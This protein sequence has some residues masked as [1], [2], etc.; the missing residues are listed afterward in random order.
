MIRNGQVYCDYKNCHL[1]IYK[2][3]RSVRVLRPEGNR[4]DPSDFAHFHDRDNTD[5][6][7][8][9]IRDA[10]RLKEAKKPTTEDVRQ[11]NLFLEGERR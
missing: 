9:T 10:E 3:Q 1:I 8:K 5:C 11:Y 2:Q 7:S 4:N 6:W